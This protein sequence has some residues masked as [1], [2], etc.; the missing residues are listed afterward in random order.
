MKINE[1]LKNKKTVSFEVFPPKKDSDDVN[2]IYATID[3]LAKLNPDF[4]SVTYGAGGS[5]VS[6]TVGIASYIKNTAKIEALAHLTGITSNE[7]D[8]IKMCETLKKNNIEN[9]M[10][11]RGDIPLSGEVKKEFEHA[12]D[13]NKFIISKYNDDF[14]LG[15]ACYPEGHPECNSLYEDLINLKI[16]QDSGASFLVSQIFFDNDYFYRLIREARKMG[17]TIPILAGIMPVTNVK[18]VN[19]IIKMCGTAVPLSL[20]TMLERYQDNKDAMWEIGVAFATYQIIDL[21]SN[22]IDGVH[23]YV[24]NNTKVAEA[25]HNNIKHI[26]GENK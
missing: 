12:S 15:G 4:I 13:L 1:I 18:Q 20:R 5:T 6:N 11:L 23:L 14:S 22:D 21:Y 17:I 25:I 16:K 19:R 24:M 10:S 9:I 26:I 7:E 3:S 2:K 8:V